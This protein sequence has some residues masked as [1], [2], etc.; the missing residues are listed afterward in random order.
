MLSIISGI[1]KDR[2]K[3]EFGII[4]II[5]TL[6]S[7]AVQLTLTTWHIVQLTVSVVCCSDVADGVWTVDQYLRSEKCFDI[8]LRIERREL[9]YGVM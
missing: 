5:E 2:L 9:S 4:I 6:K 8:N 7:Y 3:V 1:T